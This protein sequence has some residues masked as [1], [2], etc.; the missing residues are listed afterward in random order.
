MNDVDEKEMKTEECGFLE[1]FF[2]VGSDC[3]IHYSIIQMILKG[4]FIGAAEKVVHIHNSS[5]LR[6][7]SFLERSNKEQELKFRMRKFRRLG[8]LFG[9]LQN[10]CTMMFDRLFF[11]DVFTNFN[12]SF[13]QFYHSLNNIH[14]ICTDFYKNFHRFN[15]NNM[16][17]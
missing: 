15:F 1:I 6:Y 3:E 2:P 5:M 14:N 7:N 16:M 17:L 9:I 12:N 4:F 11:Y 10:V 8:R 13:M